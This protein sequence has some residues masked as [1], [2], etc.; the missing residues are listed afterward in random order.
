VV[1][2]FQIPLS[3]KSSWF[4]IHLYDIRIVSPGKSELSGSI[5]VKDGVLN[6]GKGVIVDSGTTD[7]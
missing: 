3:K 2:N 1:V 4:T 5:G 7:T 6:S